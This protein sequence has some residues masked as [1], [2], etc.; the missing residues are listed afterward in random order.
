MNRVPDPTQLIPPH[1]Q[2][3]ELIAHLDG[4]LARSDRQRVRSHLESCWDCRTRLGSLQASIEKLIEL[5]KTLKFPSAYGTDEMRIEQFRSRLMRHAAEASAGVSWW[6]RAFETVSL[7]LSTPLQWLT[8]YR[9]PA[10]AIF[11][12]AC[13]LVT[14]FTDVWTPK[15]SAETVLARV[16]EYDSAHQASGDRILRSSMQIEKIEPKRDRRRAVE[17][18]TILRDASAGPTVIE[19]EGAAGTS[20]LVLNRSSLGDALPRAL[21]GAPDLAIPVVQFLAAAHWIPDLSSSEF[22]KILLDRGS[23]QSSAK[24]VGGLF[25]LHFPFAA[26]HSSTIS[27]AVFVVDARDYAPVRMSLFAAEAGN[28]VEYRFTRSEFRSEPRTTELARLFSSTETGARPST[29]IPDHA[30]PRTT[31]LTYLNSS[32]NE[33]EVAVAATLHGTD[34]CLGE[35]V[36]IFP[37]SDGSLLVQGLMD[38]APRREA[39]R[40]ALKSVSG[41]LTIEI[42]LPRELKSGTQLLRPPDELSG[43]ESADT[44]PAAVTTLADLSNQKIPLHDVLYRH[45]QAAG[46]QQEETERQVNAFSNEVVTLA[47]QTFL[48]A[49]ALKRLD[50]EFSPARIAKLKPQVVLEIEKMREDHRR[51]I[52]TISHR[53]AQTLGSV[54]DS[55]PNTALDTTAAL[56]FDS[57]TLLRLAQEQNDLIRSLFT[58]SSRQ[59]EPSASVSRLLS[60]L[61][62]MGA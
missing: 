15:V 44:R 47:R 61:K 50:R 46:S 41:P 59:V 40:G 2:D 43:Q 38:S 11:V 7:S 31:P 42:Y 9:Q 21:M 27:E 20:R 54:I 17:K 32:A 53:Q 19:T 22:R 33:T 1:L 36:H 5:R 24:R 58:T 4:E 30:A 18:L 8:H 25:E 13:L 16:Q 34:A 10:L 56:S 39:V 45:F 49:W 62:R 12:A 6:R 55:G 29:S 35:E 23:D 48:H 26:G 3:A 51:W 57:D 52:A 60:V 37:M 14:M 28:P